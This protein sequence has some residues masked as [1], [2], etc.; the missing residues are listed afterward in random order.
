MKQQLITCL[1]DRNNSPLRWR[2][3][4]NF[5]DMNSHDCSLCRRV[6]EARAWEDRRRSTSLRAC[7]CS[8]I[9]RARLSACDFFVEKLYGM[10]AHA[11]AV[12]AC[13]LARGRPRR[14]APAF[15][16]GGSAAKWTNVVWPIKCRLTYKPTNKHTLLFYRYRRAD[17]G[18]LRPKIKYEVSSCQ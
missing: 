16:L 13:S 7:V 9:S 14:P 12:H 3:A 18:R 10:R 17:Q 8:R 2:S 6:S 5:V 15:G 1:T 11:L 4:H